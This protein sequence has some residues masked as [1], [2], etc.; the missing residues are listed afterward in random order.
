MR[1]LAA[2][3]RRPI[4]FALNQNNAEP[5]NWRVL[6][7]L[8]A[9]AI[10][11]GAPVRPQVTARTVS[12]LLGFQTFHP[13]TWTPAW[14]EAGLGLL[15]WTEQVARLTA[16]DALRARIVEE[17]H[18]L[19]DNP[20]VQGFMAPARSYVLGDP[21]NYE[22]GRGR[23]RRGHRRRSGRRR[24]ADVLDLLLG[25]GGRELLNSPVLNYSHG[26]LDATREMLVH[27]ATVFGLGDGGA[28]AGQTCDA[29]TTTFM[30]SYWARDRGEDRLSRRGRR[31]P[32]HLGHRRPL[33]PR[34]P[35]PAG[36]GH[37]GRRQ[38]HRSRSACSCAVP[39]SWPIFRAAPAGSC[40]GPTATWPPP[41][42]ARS[43]SKGA[44]RP[45][46]ALVACS[47]APGAP[48]AAG[49]ASNESAA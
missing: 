2:E 6:L 34:R 5:D 45:V 13:L 27:P 18:A 3:V 29:S 17:A 4:T 8:A 19:D 49:G 39:S 48:G 38:R 11:A 47:G 1:R 12:I 32:D 22:P 31:A 25:D 44:R 21:P 30:L 43:S 42:P 14:A 36:A 24:V 40:N 23:Q 41:T 46:R 16:D 15:P 7:D 33:R 37:E 26:N 10:A 35:G 9:D 28:H 20:I